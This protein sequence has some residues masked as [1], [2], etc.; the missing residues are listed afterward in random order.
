MMMAIV[1]VRRA[2]S[3]V[4]ESGTTVIVSDGVP[5]FMMPVCWSANVPLRP[6]RVPVTRSMAT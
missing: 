1:P 4:P 5:R 6:R 2:S 3:S